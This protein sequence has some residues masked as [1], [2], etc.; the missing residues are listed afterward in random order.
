MYLYLLPNTT[1]SWDDYCA[2]EII[3]ITD[4]TAVFVPSRPPDISP[5]DGTALWTTAFDLVPWLYSSLHSRL[6]H[7]VLRLPKDFLCALSRPSHSGEQEKRV[8]R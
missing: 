7:T 2:I 1:F 4:H 5:H 8:G 6:H 3:W